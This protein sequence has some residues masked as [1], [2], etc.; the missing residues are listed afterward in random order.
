MTT[1]LIEREN[2]MKTKLKKFLSAALIVCMLL[3]LV[4]L[5]ATE[6]FE[7]SLDTSSEELLETEELDTPPN[8]EQTETAD[9]LEIENSES[10]M[11]NEDTL[12]EIDSSSINNG[13]ATEQE[14]ILTITDSEDETEESENDNWELGLVFY[15][16]SVDNGKTPL[17]EI[18]WDASDGSYKEGTPRIITVQINY[19][20]TNTIQTYMPGELK[21]EIDG[22]LK[23][24]QLNGKI[25]SDK[26]LEYFDVSWII[27][28]NDD[29]HTNYDWEYSA[30]YE[31]RISNK[32]DVVFNIKNITFRNTNIIEEKSNFEGSIQIVYTITPKA[33]IVPYDDK[34]WCSFNESLNATLNENIKSNNIDFKYKREY[35]HPWQKKK[36]ELT[37]TA[38]KITSFDGL[39]QNCNDYIWVRYVF[40][41]WCDCSYDEYPY[42]KVNQ[43]IIEDSFPDNCKVID[44]KNFTVLN[45][46]NGKYSLYLQ[47][48][49]WHDLSY[50]IFVGYPKSEFNE[51]M[52]NL[53]ITN[54]AELYAIYGNEDYEYQD[55]DEISLNLSE[56]RFQYS[57]NL[58]EINKR[59][60]NYEGSYDRPSTNERYTYFQSL[61]G[62]YVN[63]G[64]Y[65]NVLFEHSF[66][67]KYTGNA[68][69][70]KIGDDLLFITSSDNSYRRLND[71]E[72]YMDY[73][74]FPKLFDG[75]DNAVGEKYEV[76]LYIRNSGENEYKKYT[77]FLNK[78]GY[79]NRHIKLPESTVG[80]Y[81]IIKNITTDII[82][83]YEN[84]SSVNYSS[85]IKI[86]NANDIAKSGNIYNFSYIEVYIDGILQNEPD[87]NSYDSF[88]TKDM[89]ASYDMETYNHYLQ[90]AVGTCE[91]EYY[92]SPELNE[93][94]LPQ[95]TM[96][97]FIQDIQN[98][99]F[100]GSATLKIKALNSNFHYQKGLT[101]KQYLDLYER[102]QFDV[103][104]GY[105]GFD[106]YDLLPLGM[107]LISTEDEIKNGIKVSDNVFYD[108]NKHLLTKE[109]LLTLILNNFKTEII[110]NWN[111][112]GRTLVHVNVNL[113]DNYI[114]YLKQGGFTYSIFEIKYDYRISYDSF[115]T[116]GNVWKNDMYVQCL[117]NQIKIN[118]NSQKDILDINSNGD[119]TEILGYAKDNKTIT[120]VI[121]THQDV[122]KQV[123]TDQSYYSTGTVK[124]S[125]DSEYEYKLRVRTGQNDI[126]NLVIYDSIEEYAQ[127][128]DGNIVP[129]YGSNKH[130]N[131][132][133]LGIDTSYAESKGYVV[134]PY[135]SENPLAGNLYNDDGSFNTD[136]K[137]YYNPIEPVYT[138]GL[139]IKFSDNSRTYNANDYVYIYYYKDGKYY[140]SQQLYGTNISGKEIEV[141]STDFYLYWHTNSTTRNYYGFSIDSIEPIKTENVFSSSI[142]L[143][144]NYEGIGLNG[145]NYPESEHN[146]YNIGTT[147][148]LWH[149][150]GEKILVEEGYDVI[151]MSKV[152]AL[153]FEY[154]DAEGNPA[155]LPANS[156]TYVIIKMKS[157]ADE[158]ITSLAYNGCRTQWQALD[159]Y[160][161]PVDFITGI[162]S[163]IVKVSLPNS[164]EDKEVNLHFNKM[165]SGTDEEFERLKLNKDGN[166]NFYITLEN[167]DTG[168]IIKGIVNN[169]DGFTV[170]NVPIGTY[171]IKELDGI[172][173]KF[174]S[175]ALNDSIDGIE[176]EEESGRYVIIISASVE[177]GTIANIDIT[178][179]TDDERFY[180]NKYDVKNLFSP[181]T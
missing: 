100:L 43:F 99:C 143:L 170:N 111:D 142:V 6:S 134:K 133:F 69:D 58:Y 137:E 83:K 64:D 128:P 72:Y 153:A 164:V 162:N 32:N 74:W 62:E 169:K 70:L 163:N 110:F 79:Y 31:H 139:K 16:S 95:K 61:T 115:M 117:N 130:W 93:S 145:N 165:I 112:T 96:T 91:Y 85:T 81:F 124:S 173:F 56:F 10:T 103:S 123:Q 141:P 26:A 126:T 131:G 34:L 116:Y 89:V 82:A 24:A 41:T 135:Y 49:G 7:D 53:N 25:G 88:V 19:K 171:I 158:N 151:D 132:E 172:W 11:G 121:S 4:P 138:N 118:S 13:E 59:H 44:G 66:S 167:Q 98:E 21:I 92:L 30:T 108:I 101:E 120:S 97:S 45:S 179:K 90:R 160:D 15:D 12:E 113:K 106:I 176:F 55:S 39:G 152:K 3:T 57:G 67:S 46:D 146:P 51:E 156:L 40:A 23:N 76:D 148:I 17:T 63:V 150:T 87:I 80:Y 8:L 180:D 37:K 175:M 48:S 136:W 14:D 166:Y 94:Y 38:Q 109:E 147:N 144:P 77:S 9:A 78:T 107:E 114:F 1:Y 27:G 36:H 75:N 20:N 73:I 42:I 127:N 154:L 119:Y 47:P 159:D 157:P 149:Y 177:A 29:Y 50:C 178:N 105:S 161:R 18:D 104:N 174:V 28:A 33:K 102:E 54:Y 181:T 5:N 22:L 65:G 155:K 84:N 52:D 68:Y 125:Y 129:A 140:R 168:D 71:E 86:N 122:Q 2:L 35:V 60:R